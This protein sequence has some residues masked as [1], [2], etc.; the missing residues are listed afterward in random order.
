[1]IKKWDGCGI[2]FL[3]FETNLEWNIHARKNLMNYFKK[4]KKYPKNTFSLKEIELT[5][6]YF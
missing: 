3:E 5:A 6:S 1:M 2:T 4:R